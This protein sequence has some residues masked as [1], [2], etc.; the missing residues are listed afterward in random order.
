MNLNKYKIPYENKIFMASFN[1]VIQIVNKIPK[2]EHH[3]FYNG[4]SF[5]DSPFVIYRDAIKNKAFIDIYSLNDPSEG[6]IVLAVIPSERRNGLAELLVK[7]AINNIGK[8][9]VNKLIWKVDSDNIPSIKLA[10]KLHFIENIK[11][12][13]N[14]STILEYNINNR[15][16]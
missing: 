10:K 9:R 6:I 5:K 1:D 3:Y 16:T 12:S 4:N 8:I 11:E 13:T 14:K 7:K 15:E 2:N